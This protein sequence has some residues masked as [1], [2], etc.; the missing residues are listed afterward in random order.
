MVNM[1]II[2]HAL[3]ESSKLTDYVVA[4]TC[5]RSA[6][7][8]G[9]VVRVYNTIS[10]SYTEVFIDYSL[11][12]GSPSKFMPMIHDAINKSYQSTNSKLARYL[13]GAI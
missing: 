8:D 10:N 4:T 3:K 6:S 12:A 9:L 2:E 1:G 13:R 5:Y 11:L 7:A